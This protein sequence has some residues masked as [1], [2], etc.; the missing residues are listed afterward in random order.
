MLTRE[1]CLQNRTPNTK[2][3][4]QVGPR[5]CVHVW[6]FHLLHHHPPPTHI[7]LYFKFIPS[8]RSLAGLF[9]AFGIECLGCRR[10]RRKGRVLENVPS[11]P[12][13]LRTPLRTEGPQHRFFTFFDVAQYIQTYWIHHHR[14][15]STFVNKF[16]Q[17]SAISSQPTV[18]EQATRRLGKRP[19][20]LSEQ[21]A[22]VSK[23]RGLLLLWCFTNCHLVCDE[24]PRANSA[25]SHETTFVFECSAQKSAGV[26]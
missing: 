16:I 25:Y 21:A 4:G 1:I 11:S 23:H 17:S 9:S 26:P 13:L 7:F 8:Q 3:T 5:S 22:V 12:L 2:S 15:A 6:R 18:Y 14:S 10:R 19:L 20:Q 24:A